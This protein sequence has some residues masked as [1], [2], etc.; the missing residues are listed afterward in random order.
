MLYITKRQALDAGLTHEGKLFGV[1]AWFGEDDGHICMATPK[2]PL[3]HV[4]C[5]FCDAL[6]EL[7]SY[8]LHG[9][10]VLTSPIH[11]KGLIQK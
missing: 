6:Y 4:W 5:M 7:A 9:H 10:Q 3:L 8:F 11:I 2:I 1:P